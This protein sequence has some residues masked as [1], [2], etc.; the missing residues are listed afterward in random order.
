M[1]RVKFTDI[2]LVLLIL[3]VLAFISFPG[4]FDALLQ[5]LL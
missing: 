1:K 2:V 5:R 4:I 3:A